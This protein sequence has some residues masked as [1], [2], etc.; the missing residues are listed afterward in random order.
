MMLW[1]TLTLGGIGV[2]G[3]FIVS[4]Y[5][6]AKSFETSE[7]VLSYLWKRVLRI[8]P[9]F[10]VAF[11]IC[12]AIV[13]PLADGNPLSVGD[14]FRQLAHMF[15]LAPPEVPGVFNGMPHAALNGSMWTISYEFRAYLVVAALGVMG[16]LRQRYVVLVLAVALVVANGFQLVPAIKLPAAALFGMLDVN[17]RLVG[18]FLSGTCFYLFRDVI[19]YDWRVA[20]AAAAALFGAMFSIHLAEPAIAL[21]GGYLVFWFAFKA[22][23]SA[24]SDRLRDDVSYGMYLYAWPAQG[25]IIYYGWT[26]S[27][28]VV[29][30]MATL[31]SVVLGFVS[32]KIVEAPMLR[33]KSV[34]LPDVFRRKQLA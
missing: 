28:W 26:S 5:L 15:L 24:V 14:W 34:S 30:A 22:P 9:A 19:R 21:L 6:I 18:L 29:T 7:G 25:L 10:I 32:W 13:A 20:L 23:L 3:F 12:V 27:H 2:D 16:L 11:L 31:I 1:N 17:V 33:L 4:G 8:Y